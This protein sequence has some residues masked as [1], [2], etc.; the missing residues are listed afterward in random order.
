MPSSSPS[1]DPTAPDPLAG[2]TS[3]LVDDEHRIIATR[4]DGPQDTRNRARAFFASEW[5][6][7]YADVRVS[8][9]RYRVDVEYAAEALAD[10]CE[11]PYDGWQCRAARKGEDGRDYWELMNDERYD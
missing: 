5:D 11:E 2:M 10:G 3:E 6:I 8:K 7:P 1:P 9:V 4:I